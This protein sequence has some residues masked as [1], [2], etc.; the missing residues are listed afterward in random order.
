VEAHPKVYEK[1]IAD[2]WDKKPGVRIFH[3]RWQDV[4]D[5][6]GDFDAVF[7]DTFDDV[8]GWTGTA[9][10]CACPIEVFLCFGAPCSP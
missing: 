9:A 7:F 6:L 8:S 10:G 1:M 4:V 2:G 3:A 5:Q